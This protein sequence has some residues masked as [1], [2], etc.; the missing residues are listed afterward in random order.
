MIGPRSFAFSSSA[1]ITGIGTPLSGRLL[2]YDATLLEFREFKL[3]K[4]PE[5][6]VCGESPS[7]T[8]LIDYEGFC[9]VP[10]VEQDP[11]PELTAAEL[12]TRLRDGDELLLLDVREPKEFETA[13]IEGARLIP[14]G[15]LEARLGE[16]AE[17]KDRPVVTQCKTGSRSAKAGELLR[18]AGFQDVTPEGLARLTMRYYVT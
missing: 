4:D 18:R 10:A 16:L 3:R 7:V 1:R 17:W 11:L 12:H 13:R 2:L 8:E 15:E 9:G 14:L 5:C 6:P